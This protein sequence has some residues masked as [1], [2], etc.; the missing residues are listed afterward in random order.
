MLDHLKLCLMNSQ[1]KGAR[2]AL[3]EKLNFSNKLIS[4][5]KRRKTKKLISDLS[6][7]S[8][9]LTA[10]LNQVFN[11]I[12]TN[13][14]GKLSSFELKRVLISLGHGKAEAAKEAEVMVREMDCD[15]DGF[16][17]LD[18]FMSVMES[19]QNQ[20]SEN[21]IYMESHIMD[22]FRV[23]DVDNNGLISAE[24]LKRVLGRLGC[25]KC[26]IKECRKMIKGVDRDGDGFVDFEEFKYMMSVGC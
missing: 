15:G 11:L 20:D 12:D 14:D 10:Q 18:E 7:L 22:A 19:D 23:F 24:E 17:D 25:G 5:I 26:S 21:G 9:S 3:L 4:C 1:F 6:C 13:G 16:V 8:S 2:K